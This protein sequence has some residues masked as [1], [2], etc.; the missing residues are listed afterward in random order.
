LLGARQVAGNLLMCVPQAVTNSLAMLFIVL[1]V[2]G[3]VSSRPLAG[4]FSIVPLTLVTVTT[5]SVGGPPLVAMAL[6]LV[7]Y[8]GA[9]LVLLRFGLVALMSGFFVLFVL[10]SSMVTGDLS[11]WYGATSVC[12]LMGLFAIAAY[13]FYAALYG[14]KTFEAPNG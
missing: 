7:F 11:S 4:L 10:R 8:A 13:G 2:G 9:T 3:L 6:W 12:V 5:T 1:G 14:K